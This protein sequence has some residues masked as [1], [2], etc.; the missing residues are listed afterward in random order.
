MERMKVIAVMTIL[1]LL[2]AIAGAGCASLQHAE[3]AG[4]VVLEQ[5]DVICLSLPEDEQQQICGEALELA[6]LLVAI[7]DRHAALQRARVLEDGHPTTIE[8]SGFE[9]LPSA[10][11]RTSNG[12]APPT[13]I[14]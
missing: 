1:L 7:A 14:F 11:E 4:R 10:T 2:C 6:R 8:S 12:G 5:G 9:P 13:P 3:P